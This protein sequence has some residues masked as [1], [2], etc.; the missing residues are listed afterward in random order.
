[1]MMSSI[2][3]FQD[4]VFFGVLISLAS[5]GIGMLLKM[6]TLKRGSLRQF[7]RRLRSPK[8][9]K[10]PRSRQLLRPM[11]PPSHL[12]RPNQLTMKT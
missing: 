10:R 11:N 9:L 12:K 4:S 8:R 5:Y 1:M 3:L 2:S 6:K 7:L